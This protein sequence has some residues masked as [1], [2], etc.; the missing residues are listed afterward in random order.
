MTASECACVFSDPADRNQIHWQKVCT[1]DQQRRQR[2]QP[3][4]RRL[5]VRRRPLH[6]HLELLVPVAAAAA[7]GGTR[8]STFSKRVLA[9]NKDH[10]YM[11]IRT[12]G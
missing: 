2:R 4:S 3:Q 9:A 8:A 5:L 7:A 6:H 12:R 11:Y 1:W 10:C